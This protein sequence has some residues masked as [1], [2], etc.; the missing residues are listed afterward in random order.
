MSSLEAGGLAI[1]VCF[2]C[3]AGRW[4]L[5]E[6]LVLDVV[7]DVLVDGRLVARDLLC[8]AFS[9]AVAAVAALPSAPLELVQRLC[10]VA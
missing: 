1:V 9:A 6:V 10:R 4:E 2:C 3:P 7:L 8:A 5:L